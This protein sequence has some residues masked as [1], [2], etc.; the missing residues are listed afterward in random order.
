MKATTSLLA[1][2]V[3]C[4][5]SAATIDNTVQPYAS[6]YLSSYSTYV[7][8]M[9]GGDIQIWWEVMGTGYMDEIGTLSIRLYESTDNTNWTHVKTF[10]HESNSKMLAQND[11]FHCDY[12]SYQGNSSRYY[13]AY[14]CI[15]AGKNGNGD[16]R[17]MWATE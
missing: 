8:D 9:G 13:K 4:T 17:Y 1:L 12:V 14:V 15:W 6:N 16:T 3:P 2:L 5:V 11:Y 7:C 10:L